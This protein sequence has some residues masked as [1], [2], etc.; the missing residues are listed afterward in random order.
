MNFGGTDF[1]VFGWETMN[2]NQQWIDITS[3]RKWVKAR[4]QK[5]E[6]VII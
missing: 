1:M 6:Y 4:I 2:D 3:K 5:A